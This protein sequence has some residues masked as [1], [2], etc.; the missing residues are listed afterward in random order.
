[1]G[2]LQNRLVIKASVTLRELVVGDCQAVHA[3]AGL[4]E[5][6]RYQA[7]GPNTEEQ[8]R[9]FVQGAVDDRLKAPQT[10]FAYAVC[11]DGELIGIGELKVRSQVH[12]QGEI[13]YLVHPRVWGRG[14]GTAI[15]GELLSRGF[16]QLGLHRIYATCDPRNLGSSRV[17]GK[18]GMTYEG[19][20]R[21]TALI[22]DGWRDSEVFSILDEEW[23]AGSASG[24]RDVL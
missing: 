24:D 17:L 2:G 16:G 3:F 19:R 8:T 11:L 21:H 14:V 6:C 20:H 15:G 13:S 5:A 10:R 4:P 23:G 7:W 12:R 1:M 22:R 9:A 18:L